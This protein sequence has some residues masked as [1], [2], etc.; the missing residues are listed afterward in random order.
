[1][2]KD[3]SRSIV[4]RSVG[5]ASGVATTLAVP[6]FLSP[7]QQGYFYTFASVLSIQVFFELGLGQALLYKFSSYAPVGPH[8]L[9]PGKSL[10]LQSLLYSSR[11]IY[12]MITILFCLVASV[13]GLIFF[14]HSGQPSGQWRP[15]WLFL[16]FVTS[17]NLMQSIKLVFLE[18]HGRVADVATLRLKVCF[19]SSI[20]FFVVL[21]LGGG[22]W[23]A[24]VVPTLNA[25]ASSWWIY[26]SSQA[27]VYRQNR[28]LNVSP[29]LSDMS[30][31]W[32]QEI[33]PLQW[34][35]SLSW[36]SGYFIFQLITPITFSRFGPVV[37]GQLGFA[38]SAMNSIL[39]V[40][41]TFTTA[42][43]PRLSS[44][45]HAGMIREY[46]LLFDRSLAR[47]V[48]AI[49]LLSALFVFSVYSLSAIHVGVASRFLS[50]KLL[51]LYSLT[52]VVSAIAYCWAIYLR[53][54]SIE[55]LAVQSIV[56]AAVMA[57]SIW[58]F[59]YASLRAMLIAMLLVTFASSVAVW[60]IYSLNR[61]GLVGQCV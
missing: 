1:M 9:V 3:V 45:F 42:I 14:S 30:R 49:I 32:S 5:L 31:L 25:V 43:A 54:Q 46:N 59:S 26:G 4:Q 40:A 37:A 50:W 53:S 36:L 56:T 61:R 28:N 60:R 39:F 55:P 20:L 2:N 35:T 21:A 58:A 48:S 27:L 6:F 38:I 16:V 57:P 24:T 17:I 15:Q 23:A 19:F 8:L 13:V 52:V 11:R 22:L 18:S 44:L 41:T 51:L 10:E 33:F 12:I 47:S 34:R 7:E 29:K